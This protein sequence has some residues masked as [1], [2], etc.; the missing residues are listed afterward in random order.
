MMIEIP[1]DL[2]TTLIQLFRH[3]SRR[4]SLRTEKNESR[5][6]ERNQRKLKLVHEMNQK[7]P[8]LRRKK[9]ILEY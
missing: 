9:I 1:G 5:Q 7:A 6:R 3:T 4:P 2:F 8:V